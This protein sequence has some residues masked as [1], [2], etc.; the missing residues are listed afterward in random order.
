MKKTCAACSFDGRDLAPHKVCETQ[1]GGRNKIPF[2]IS[3]A[4]EQT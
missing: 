1:R 4:A 3:R 2:L